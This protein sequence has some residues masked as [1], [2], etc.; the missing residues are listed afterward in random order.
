MPGNKKTEKFDPFNDRLARD[1]RNGLARALLGSLTD[2]NLKDTAREAQKFL[3]MDLTPGQYDY[4]NDRL[5]R[6]WEA[7][8]LIKEHGLAHRLD[9]ALALWDLGLF[10]EVHDIL[11]ELWQEAAGPRRTA[12]KGLI[13]AAA[14]Y[15]HRAQGNG[16]AA[17]K[18]A[19]KAAA[20]LAAHRAQLPESFPMGRL[21][22]ALDNLETKP[23]KLLGGH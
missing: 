3:A 15:I 20:A 5:T 16:P 13:Q 10:F 7:L 11:E 4:I 14:V 18:M 2:C 9:K 12:L 17:A 22:A 23:P 21:L 1:I 19:A 8:T 6:Y